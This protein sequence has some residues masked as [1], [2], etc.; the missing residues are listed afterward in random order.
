MQ[1]MIQM[2]AES[3][4]HLAQQNARDLWEISR[5]AGELGQNCSPS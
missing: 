5:S 4:L 1:G 2:F 3:R